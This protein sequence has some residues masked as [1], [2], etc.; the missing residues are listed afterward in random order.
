MRYPE[1][2]KIGDT[3]GIC[4]PSAGIVEPEKVEKLNQA[5]KQL[6]SMGYKVI[7]T[8]SVR[9]DIKGRSTTAKKRVEELMELWNNEE[10]KLI[11]YAGGG[12]FLMEMIDEVDFENLKK[13]PP[14]WTQGFSDITTISFLLNTICDMPSMYCESIKDY[15]MKPLYRNLEDSLKL[16]SG[17][18]IIQESFE[19]YSDGKEGNEDYTYNLTLE[20]KWRNITGEK[21][22]V[23][24]GRALGGCLDCIDTLIGTKYDKVKE[25]IQKY[26][27]DGIVWFLECYETNTPGLERTL[28]KMKNAG[29]F[30]HCKGIIFGRPYILREDYEIGEDEAI[31]SAL[32][33][34]NIPIITGADIG[35]VPPQLAIMQG[36]I[37]K[38]TSKD[39]KGKVETFKN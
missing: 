17:E 16:I 39:G 9:K 33:K 15:A 27:Q 3:I 7:E 38:I 36:A 29:Y 37:L 30:E 13:L 22:I 21:E 24:K 14:K 1:D 2:L 6:K 19:K 11:L 26:K 25:Y 28:W 20:T 8:E 4:A 35:H 34:L 10:V 5:I 18:D 31:L 23:I 12:D 32:E